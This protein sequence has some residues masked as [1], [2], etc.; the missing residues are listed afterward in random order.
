MTSTIY[1][2]QF[3]ELWDRFE[4]N[5]DKP[6]SF[7]ALLVTDQRRNLF[8]KAYLS[9]RL[10]DALVRQKAVASP[11]KTRREAAM[12]EVLNLLNLPSPRYKG[13]NQGGS[14][15]AMER[16]EGRIVSDLVDEGEFGKDDVEQIV[17]LASLV[18]CV[19]KENVNIVRQFLPFPNHTGDINLILEET[20]KRVNELA[21]A[22]N[23]NS[24]LKK[25]FTGQVKSLRERFSTKKHYQNCIEPIYGDFAVNNIIKSIDGRLILI[26]PILCMGRRS[27]DLGRLGRSI[28]IRNPKIFAREFSSMVAKYNVV[29]ENAVEVDEVIDM[30][31]ADLMRI[32]S[33]FLKIPNDLLGRFPEYIQ[34][35]RRHTFTKYVNEIIPKLLLGEWNF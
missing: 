14:V 26:D 3:S 4:E 23:I 5:R 20:V 6:E 31:T 33:L 1:I 7:T 22:R 29:A 30:M 32:L 16:V 19:L 11:E 15:L 2:P 18:H 17:N 28:I 35:V 21:W 25:K 24:N 12:L 27:M 13:M 10:S 8:Y 9:E 34:T